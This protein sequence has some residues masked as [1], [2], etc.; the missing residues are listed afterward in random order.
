MG[1]RLFLSLVATAIVFLLVEGV[2]SLGWR[3]SWL[4]LLR[5]KSVLDSGL[6][7]ALVQQDQDRFLAAAR[8]PGVY[9][10]HED[11]R[12]GFVLKSET[13]LEI[14][15]ATFRTNDL[16]L[17]VR[18]GPEPVEEGMR[19]AVLGDSVAFGW[20]LEANEVLAAQLESVLQQVQD[21]TVPPIRCWTVAVPGWSYRNSTSFLFDHLDRL[22]PDLVLFMTCG[23]DL[24]NTFGVYETGH[25][26]VQPDP[27]ARDPLLEYGVNY[28]YMLQLGKRIKQ[29]S[30]EKFR[31]NAIG[32]LILDAGLSEES[33]W[34]LEDMTRT[35]I[36]VQ[37]RLTA[38][39]IEFLLVP[40]EQHSLHNLIRERLLAANVELPIIPLLESTVPEDTLE[41]DPHPNAETVR[42]YALWIAQSL[43]ER[44]LVPANTGTEFP[45]VPERLRSRRSQ[46]RN[47][48]EIRQWCDEY[49]ASVEEQLMTEISDETGRGI[50]QFYGGINVDGSMGRRLRALLARNGNRLRVE[51]APYPGRPDLYPMSIEV[52]VN[53]GVLGKVVIPPGLADDARVV[54]TFPLPDRTDEPIEVGLTPETWGVSQVRGKSTVV[55]C[56]FVSLATKE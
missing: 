2:L 3:T 17:R 36:D 53:G 51:L 16:G 9:R 6:E 43:T 55:S 45:A 28:A 10:V 18:P 8:V 15:H 27:F 35:L 23:N 19:I 34:R 42:A 21:P 29:R 20:G 5:R 22:D 56:Q 49:R 13:E 37:R 54:E 31:K 39:G 52:E 24:D 4:E 30:G 44:G 50:M 47:P 11:P 7:A 14:H 41:N 26:R 33:R 25:R 32:P 48:E 46:V 1:K 40:F 38:Q 12:V